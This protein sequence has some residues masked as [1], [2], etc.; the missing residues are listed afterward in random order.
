[1]RFTFDRYD[2]TYHYKDAER[3]DKYITANITITSKT[4]DPML[5]GF[6]LYCMDADSALNLVGMFSY[7]LFRWEDY[8]TYLGNYN[9]NKNDFAYSESIKF[10]LGLS[11][12]DSLLNK[13]LLVLTR[14]K[15][16]YTRTVNRYD[17]PPVSYISSGTMLN[18]ISADYEWNENG[19]VKVA[20]IK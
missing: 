11:M 1:N 14:E 3:G 7:R 8:G 13:K 2:D 10:A 19:Y 16:F 4:K 6:G 18:N 15:P 20:E 5:H 17:T 9:D 12:P